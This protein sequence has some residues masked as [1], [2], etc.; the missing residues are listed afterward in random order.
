[1]PDLRSLDRLFRRLPLVL[2]ACAGG[3]LAQ[4]SAVDPEALAGVMKAHRIVLLGE[5]HDNPA[6][7]A[8]RAAALRRWVET[9]ARPAILMEQFDRERQPEIDRALDVPTA[10]PD[11]VIAAGVAGDPAQA[12]WSWPFYRPY[13]ALALEYRLPLLAVNVSRA[14]VRR[15]VAEGLQ[16]DGFDPVVPDDIRKAQAEAIVAGHCGRI[17]AAGAD[18]L[19]A[20]QVARDQFMAHAIEV[21]R[22]QGAVLLAGNG[23]VRRDIGVPRWLEPATRRQAVSIGLVESADEAPAGAFDRA[24]KTVAAIR[25]DPCAGL[26]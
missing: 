22:E 3:A 4:T 20:A 26:R 13:I 17:D 8:A 21:A 23:H 15:I 7:H 12:G 19:V 24:W 14:D 6:Q 9:G 18:R 10:T 16:A 1:M 5:V 11:G 25:T 2:A